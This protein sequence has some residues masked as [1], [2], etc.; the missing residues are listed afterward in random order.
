M[1]VGQ[2]WPQSSESL[3]AVSSEMNW[4]RA[5]GSLDHCG[6]SDH[7]PTDDPLVVALQRLLEMHG[8]HVAVGDLAGINDQSLYQIATLRT[9]SKTGR[10]KGIGPS[11][12]RRLD[13]AFPG[14]MDLH[15]SIPGMDHNMSLRIRDTPP[16]IEWG[17]VRKMDRMTSTFEVELIDDAMA[18]KAPAGTQVRFR[19]ATQ[20]SPGDA[21]L[22][23]DARGE[24]HFREHRARADGSWTAYAFN[25]AFPS[26]HSIDD[27][28]LVIGVAVGITIGWQTLVR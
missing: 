15:H 26:L 10:V 3:D 20:S 2:S 21:V 9:D 22:V 24:I 6:M 28:L 7:P 11:I 1:P 14:W 8:G 23:R 19:S 13:A 25:P 5:S 4:R 12:R 18:P 17:V 27:G 16:K